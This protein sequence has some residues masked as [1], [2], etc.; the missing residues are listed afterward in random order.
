MEILLV[1]ERLF[2]KGAPVGLISCVHPHVYA[3]SVAP[4]KP[5]PA[6]IANETFFARVSSHVVR[7]NRV[8][9]ETVAALRTH[10]RFLTTVRPLVH[11]Q[12]GGARETLA[13]TVAE[14]RLLSRMPSVVFGKA[15][16]SFEPSTTLQT[17]ER[18]LVCVM[19]LVVLQSTHGTEGLGTPSA[20]V[21]PFPGVNPNVYLQFGRRHKPQ[22]A[23]DTLVRLLLLVYASLMIQQVDALRKS[24][25]AL[26]ACVRPLACVQPLVNG[27]SR[28]ARQNLTALFALTRFPLDYFEGFL[29]VAREQYGCIGAF[30]G[31]RI[32]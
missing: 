27:E 15:V 32:R 24:L 18:P 29:L 2:A 17:K 26:C 31:S 14:I 12:L 10:V 9:G 13:A 22:R 21:G 11:N 8:V 6:N 28:A 7:Q 19:N 1:G 16:F 3:E 25:T 30:Y 20:G 23:M 4:G 5:L